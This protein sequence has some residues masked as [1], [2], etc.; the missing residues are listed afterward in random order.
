MK[1]LLSALMAVAFALSLA[2]VALAETKAGPEKPAEPVKKEEGTK[3]AAQDNTAPAKAAPAE[4][5]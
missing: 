5:K 4:K 2:T 1:K 3:P